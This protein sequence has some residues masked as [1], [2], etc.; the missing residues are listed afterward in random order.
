[1]ELIIG[2]AIPIILTGIVSYLIWSYRSIVTYEVTSVTLKVGI[3][4]N[5]ISTGEDIDKNSEKRLTSVQLI[6]HNRGVKS[7]KNFKMHCDGNVGLFDIKKVSTNVAKSDI[8]LSSVD[9]GIQVEIAYLPSKSKVQLEFGYLDWNIHF[10]NFKGDGENYN[11][12]PIHFWNGY[13]EVRLAALKLFAF[14][15]FLYFS[16]L[17]VSA[18]ADGRKKPDVPSKASVQSNIQGVPKP[19]N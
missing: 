16:I 12:K 18:I 14:F 1:M 5:K 17:I 2:A 8:G 15:S 4:G 6:I 13:Q 19:S 9:N 7:I 10:Y 11:V 3:S